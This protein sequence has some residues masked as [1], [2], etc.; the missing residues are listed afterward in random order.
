M[1]TQTSI[2]MSDKDMKKFK[3]LKKQYQADSGSELFR[4]ILNNEWQQYQKY[5]E[6]IEKENM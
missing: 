6:I 2:Y 4:I 1:K 3:E 5:K